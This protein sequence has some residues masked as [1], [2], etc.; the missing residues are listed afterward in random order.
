MANHKNHNQSLIEGLDLGI[1]GVSP[2]GKVRYANARF[3]EILGISPNITLRGK[4]LADYVAGASVPEFSSA[5]AA[6]R[7]GKV[8]GEIQ[9]LQ[10]DN[11]RIVG[12]TFERIEDRLPTVR[13]VIS[14]MTSAIET[15]LTLKKY[16]ASMQSLSARILQ[17]QD[18]ERRRIARELHDTSGQD[19]AVLLMS[20]SQLN[21]KLEQAG[22]PEGTRQTLAD[23]MDLARNVEDQIR[24]LSY[25]LHP[26]LL[27]E[28]GI[29]AALRWYAEGFKK[30]TGIEVEIL[31]PQNALRLAPEH[32]MA[33]FR[34]VQECLS[35]ILRHSESNRARIRLLFPKGLAEV[36]VR[37]YGK[38]ISSSKLAEAAKGRS[39]G[40]GIAGMRERL[41]QIGGKIEIRSGQGGT[42]VVACV[43]IETCE[44][45]PEPVATTL[46]EQALATLGQ[47]PRRILIAD[48]H[49]VTRRGI[50]S[51]LQN[52][53]DLEVCGEAGD[54]IEAV[55]KTHEMHP[56]LII[57][58]L[59]MPRCGGFGALKRLREASSNTRI[60][61]FTTHSYAHL[62]GTLRAS[63]CDGYVSKGTPPEELLRGI[64][65]VLQGV[66]YFRQEA[67]AATAG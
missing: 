20:L 16:E 24:T 49:E 40:V 45:P 52:E 26:P 37:D 67:L 1:A 31:S 60:L 4:R 11:F 32:E 27:D 17:L 3:A 22:V 33:L 25:L 46:A 21:R 61:V 8:E 47:A 7:N 14:E 18:Q 23:A 30:R 59:T 9:V 57:L 36:S 35:N 48:D 34:V 29:G 44:R 54:G 2:D 50:R 6:T 19:L 39:L 43:P 66:Q 41:E 28:L 10:G 12:A 13:I 15:K 42:L 53:H 63:G 55:A 5:L 64:R 56:D 65:T 62:I 51:L 58:D 38:G